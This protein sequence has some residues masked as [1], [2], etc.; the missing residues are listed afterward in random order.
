MRPVVRLAAL[1]ACVALATSRL[2]LLGHELVGHGGMAVAVGAKVTEVK[3]FWFA[4][5]WI[6]YV[7]A[8]G[9]A[10]VLAIAMAGIGV[11]L[12]AGAALWLAVRG[13][14]LGRRI[15]RG[16]AAGLVLHATWYL[17]TGAFSGFG[18][19]MVLY[20]V[21]GG[22]RVPVAIAA[23]AVTCTAAYAGA[24]EVLGAL[25][26]TLPRW[27]IAG[28]IT[29]L[30]A[31]AA[32][33]AALAVGELRLRADRTYAETMAP[34]RERAIARW[35]EGHPSA[36]APVRAAAVHQIEDEHPTFPFVWVLAIATLVAVIAGARRAKPAEPGLVP[37]RLLA[38]WAT[39]AIVAIAIVMIV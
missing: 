33:H 20:R 3:L 36:P 21:L 37:A 2:G 5:G 19:G 7:G 39:A 29:A 12:V 30:A 4:G 25:A 28:T 8:P 27:R 26:A 34:E 15:V 35:D 16:I 38:T 31:A 18:D 22:W 23:G 1:V 17:A 11:E 9:L 32:L 6:R 10:A 14:S 24:R 13:D